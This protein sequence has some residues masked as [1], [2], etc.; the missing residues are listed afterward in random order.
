MMLSKPK[1]IR[2]MLEAAPPAASATPASITFQPTVKYSRRTARRRK[3]SGPPPSRLG[4]I[5]GMV[6]KVYLLA[7]VGGAFFPSQV[8][9]SPLST[10]HVPFN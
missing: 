5:T 3:A 9:F 4:S 1:P 6:V 10:D 7:V 8:P 2:A